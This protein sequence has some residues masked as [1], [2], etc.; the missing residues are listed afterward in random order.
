MSTYVVSREDLA[1]NVRIL[2]EKAGETP[3]WAV[4]KAEGYGLGAGAFAK[5]L[6]DLGIRDFCVTEPW[7]AEEIRS[8][9][10][11]DCSILMLRQISDPEQIRGMQKLG[12][13]LTVGSL[14][15]AERINNAVDS[16]VSVHLKVDT[17]M[18][19]YGFLPNELS[20]MV[21]LFREGKHL[22]IE[23]MYT[24]F[25]CAFCNDALTKAQFAEFCAVVSALQQEGCDT[26]TVHC[27]NSGAFL[28][29]PEMHLGAVRL[30]S[31][32]LGRMSF[33]TKL[34]PLG[35]VE[36]SVEELHHIPQGQSTGYGA[37]WKSKRE[38]TLA[39]LP[40]G[41]C[42]GLQV[43]C[44]E[45]RSRAVDCIRGGLKELKNLLKRPKTFVMISGQPC[46]IVGAIGS[47]HC[48]VDVTGVECR[49]GQAVELAINPMHVKGMEVQ[50]R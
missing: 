31:A 3:I 10:I 29:F 48:A 30:G 37:I 42:N 26:G 21:S 39:I 5:E 15:A 36:T 40:V 20:K 44:R 19:R 12:V 18:G 14:E 43:A 1:Y 4:V 16:P 11:S 7:E 28:K 38:S 33:P 32:L 22:R 23:G 45:D 41:W 13:V 27:C 9:G 6:Y 24:H 47:L 35:K 50:F 49:I 2:R 25:N 46:P 34:R 17:G 8:R